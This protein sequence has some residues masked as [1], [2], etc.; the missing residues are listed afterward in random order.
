MSRRQIQYENSSFGMRLQWPVEWDSGAITDVEI[1]VKDLSGNEKLA[2]TS[3]TLFAPDAIRLNGD[4]LAEA[5]SVV[6]E[7][8]GAGSLP[9]PLPGDTIYIAAGD[10]GPG[11][12]CEVESYD[13]AT[14]SISLVRDLR[15]DHA[16]ETAVVG[17]YCTYSIDVSDT[18]DYPLGKQLVITL[19]PDTDDLPARERAEIVNA[20]HGT[21]DF[22]RDFSKLFPVEYEAIVYPEGNAEHMLALAKEDIRIELRYRG[23]DINRVVDMSLLG[24]VIMNKLRWLVLRKERSEFASD[25]RDAC[26]EEYQREFELLCAAP[27]WTDDNQDE[28]SNEDT[29]RDDHIQWGEARGL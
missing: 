13:S 14:N 27:I 10:D 20:A 19:T 15:Y 28:V 12:H 26:I 6:I 16:D 22:T 9:T 3:T 8:A 17:T 24:P 7:L 1:T 5:S 29:E 2:A 11:E 23:L 21:V 25:Q 18:D 4:V